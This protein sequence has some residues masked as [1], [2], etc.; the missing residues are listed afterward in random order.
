MPD[1][2]RERAKAPGEPLQTVCQSQPLE[3]RPLMLGLVFFSF[4]DCALPWLVHSILQN[5]ASWVKFRRL[6]AK[7]ELWG[8]VNVPQ[9]SDQLSRRST[10][11]TCSGTALRAR[12]YI[13]CEGD[14]VSC[15]ATEA[16]I[17]RAMGQEGLAD[18]DLGDPHPWDNERQH[19]KVQDL[20]GIIPPSLK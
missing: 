15:S 12:P 3:W 5:S 2:L 7:P 16:G 20:T 9:A 8:P 1:H 13:I 4:L 14:F 19:L 17:P 11:P 18:W 10:E 6:F